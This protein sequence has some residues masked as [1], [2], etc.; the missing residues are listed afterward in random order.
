M[1][2]NDQPQMFPVRLQRETN[3]LPVS[4]S[5]LLL[6]SSAQ[7]PISLKLHMIQFL[8]RFSNLLGLR[9]RIMLFM[10]RCVKDKC[11]F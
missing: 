2:H 6:Q 11:E 8:L 9:M 4:L 7:Q 10:V 5:L 3:I 1:L